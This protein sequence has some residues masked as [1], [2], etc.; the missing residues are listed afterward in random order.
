MPGRASARRRCS[1]GIDDGHDDGVE[2]V[3]EAG[4]EEQRNI[5]NRERRTCG[6]RLRT[7]NAAMRLRTS[8]M[9]S[10]F[11]LLEPLRVRR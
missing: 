10:G 11:K 5:H 6:L 8:G 9:N 1:L 7:R 4:L 3:V 2:A